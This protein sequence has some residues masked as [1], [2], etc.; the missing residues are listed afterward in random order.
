MYFKMKNPKNVSSNLYKTM[1]C[2][3][4]LVKDCW[5]IGW[6]DWWFLEAA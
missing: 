3:I 1:K 5:V 2:G 6:V 4:T